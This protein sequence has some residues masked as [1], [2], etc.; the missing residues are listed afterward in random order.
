MNSRSKYY[1]TA[2]TRQEN[3]TY[4]SREQHL[5]VERTALRV[6]RCNITDYFVILDTDIQNIEPH[7]FPIKVCI[8]NVGFYFYKTICIATY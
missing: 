3:S 2:H 1:E 7:F 4:A 6:E 5:R 8:W